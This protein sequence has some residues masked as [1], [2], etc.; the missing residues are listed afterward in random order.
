MNIRML[1]KED[2]RK[3]YLI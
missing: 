1:N 2:Q 3:R